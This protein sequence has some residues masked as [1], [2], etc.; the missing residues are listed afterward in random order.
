M[1]RPVKPSSSE[2]EAALDARRHEAAESPGDLQLELA[3]LERRPL[4]L[5]A[6]AAIAVAGVPVLHCTSLC[7]LARA[8][9][10]KWCLVLQG[11]RELVCGW[12]VCK[13][14]LIYSAS[15]LGTFR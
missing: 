6:A 12:R 5:V 2:A 13:A 8:F 10:S 7:L 1:S 3:S 9:R 11:R 4:L 14:E 15:F